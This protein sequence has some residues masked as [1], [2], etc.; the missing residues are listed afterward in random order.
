MAFVML[1]IM[2]LFAKITPEKIEGTC[3]AFLTGTMNF[4]NSVVSPL[5]GSYINDYFVGVKR[6]DFSQMYIL[7]TI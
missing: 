7:M 1:P 4:K 2:V 3:F 6:E 5:V